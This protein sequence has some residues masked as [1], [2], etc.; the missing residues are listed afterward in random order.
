MKRMKRLMMVTT[1]AFTLIAAPVFAQSSTVTTETTR[2][3]EV[4]APVPLLPPDPPAP[5]LMV[6]G[7]SSSSYESHSVTHSDNGVQRTDS[8]TEKYIAP[9]GTVHTRNVVTQQDSR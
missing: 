7:Q 1:A 5:V 9:D 3:T 2:T 8:R 4:P 6:P